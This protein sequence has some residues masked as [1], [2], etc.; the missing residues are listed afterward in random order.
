MTIAPEQPVRTDAATEAT[1]LPPH[2]RLLLQLARLELDPARLAQ[3]RALAADEH[4]DWGAF[5]D[6]AA[7]HKLLPLVGRH[8]FTYRIDRAADGQK[9]FPYGWVFTTAYVGNRHRNLA[10]ADEFGR[11]FGELSQAGI[12]HAV[13]KGF[14]LA[15]TAYGD[16][17]VRKINDL[18]LLV[19]RDDA[20]RAHEVLERLGYTQGQLAEDSEQVKPFSRKTQIF[21][22][23]NLSNQLPYVKAGH[24]PDLPEFN[25]DLCHD[26]FQKKSG[27]TAP[28][29]DLLVRADPVRLCGA[30][31]WVPD[32]LDRLLDLCSHLHK[33]ATSLRFIEDSV[34]L[35]ISKFLD[36]A[37][38][39]AGFRPAQWEAFR[40]RVGEYGAGSIAYY[41]LHFTARLYPEAVPTDVLDALRPRDTGYLDQYGTLDGQVGTWALGFL[42]RLFDTGRK[43]GSG[44]SNVPHE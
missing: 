32:P 5:L 15:E 11:L 44:R 8:V 41:S 18:D 28:A 36:I 2:A 34:D 4:L 26:I 19:A 38:V 20:P 3:V 12:R 29:A 17:A 40:A 7:R 35:Q 25:V 42:E 27:V 21:W 43:A 22:K 16:P 31:T 10:L 23:V 1:G 37:L 14:S 9:G 13:R 30:S 33:E 6:A 24:R 39:A